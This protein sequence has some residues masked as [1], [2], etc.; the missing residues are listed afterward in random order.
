MPSGRHVT[1]PPCEPHLGQ[2]P[3]NSHREKGQ[4]VPHVPALAA[5]TK[6]ATVIASVETSKRLIEDVVDVNI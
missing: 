1:W 2:P 3:G 4:E 5:L 6:L